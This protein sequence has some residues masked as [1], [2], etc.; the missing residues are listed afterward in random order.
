[1][2]QPPGKLNVTGGIF[3]ALIFLFIFGFFVGLPVFA[4]VL[5]IAAFIGLWVATAGKHGK[6]WGTKQPR[7]DRPWRTDTTDEK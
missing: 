2:E 1:M 3:A 7:R 5:L 4:W 6:D